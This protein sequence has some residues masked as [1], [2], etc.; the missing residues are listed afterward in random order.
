MSPNGAAASRRRSK[1]FGSS[2]AKAGRGRHRTDGPVRGVARRGAE[3]AFDNCSDLI[4]INGARPARAGFVQEPFDA[5][6]QKAPTPL[7]NCMLMDT[8]F[9]RNGFAGYA[10]RAAQDDAASLRQRTRHAMTTNLP[11]EIRALIR[12]EDQGRN[13]A[14]CRVG[15]NCAPAIFRMRHVIMKRTSVPGD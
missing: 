4:V 11:F 8:Q 2:C 12:A 10:I 5:P 9:V 13:R 15:H 7:A 3:R 1:S 6:L 14:S